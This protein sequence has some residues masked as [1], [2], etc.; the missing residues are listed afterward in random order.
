M[1]FDYVRRAKV[2]LTLLILLV[3]VSD[4]YFALTTHIF[5]YIITIPSD[6]VSLYKR[7]LEP[8]KQTLPQRAFLGYVGDTD[9]GDTDDLRVQLFMKRYVL[10]RYILA[11]LIIIRRADL[12]IVIGDFHDTR[13]YAV[14]PK[15]NGLVLMR[16]LGN[17]V[18]LFRRGAD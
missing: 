2:A 15:S 12:P 9:V 5:N 4:A 1:N 6:E 7:R 3:F 13:S 8:L 18:R 10:T 17:G 11:P 16:D 14:I